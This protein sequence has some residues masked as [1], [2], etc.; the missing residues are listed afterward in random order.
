MSDKITTFDGKEWLIEDLEKKAIDDSFYYGYLAKNVL[1][2][3][4]VKLLNKSPKDYK[5]MLEGVQKGSKALEEGKLIHTMLLEPDK[6]SQ[7]NIV[8]TTTRATKVFKA[9]LAEN[10]NTFTQK[11]YDH[12]RSVA[13]AV[14]NNK[15]I[16]CFNGGY[17]AEVPVIGEISGVP[18][19]AKADLISR[20][21][22]VLI[23]IKT[24]G[25]MDR[26]KWDVIN[27]GYHMQAYIYC[28]LFD[29]SYDDYFYLVVDKKTRAVG[30]FTLTEETYFKGL[31]ETEKAIDQYKKYFVDKEEDVDDF[32]IF[33][34]V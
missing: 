33:G 22:G 1:S 20:E 14:L 26:F 27:F 11:E 18:F 34:E 7:V 13:D 10:P 32:T 5:D 17:E 3:S 2:S 15:S 6:L 30:V 8:D 24:T 4:S 29:I 12:C 28:E 19:R 16:D 9:A 25:D 23:D 31:E 21:N